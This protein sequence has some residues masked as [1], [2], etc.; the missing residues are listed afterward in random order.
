[1]NILYIGQYRD[2]SINGLYSSIILENLTKK[3]NVTSRYAITHNVTLNNSALFFSENNLNDKYDAVIQHLPVNRLA[4][5]QHIKTNIAIP[6]FGPELLSNYD[7]EYLNLFDQVLSD[8]LIQY[9]YLNEVL[10]KP[11]TLYSLSYRDMTRDMTQAISFPAYSSNNIL[12]TIIEYQYNIEYIFDLISEFLFYSLD[13]QDICLVIYV[14]NANNMIMQ[15]IQ[16]Q[17][18]NGQ[19]LC[20]INTENLSKVIIMP[21]GSQQIDLQMAHYAGNIFLNIHDYPNNA[22]HSNLAS[23]NKKP[24]INL[25]KNNTS[26]TLFRNNVFSENGYKTLSKTSIRN[27]FIKAENKLCNSESFEA[28]LLENII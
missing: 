19:K 13:K 6:I 9:E 21:I 18:N 14:L 16:K 11:S 3:H 20:N 7:I 25:D 5:T 2:V 23:I 27:I 1:M 8:N 15:E 28:P 26:F 22:L 17:I 4:Y 12:Y 24:T 10:N